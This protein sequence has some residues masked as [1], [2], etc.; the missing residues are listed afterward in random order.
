MS[1]IR[2]SICPEDFSMSRRL[3]NFSMS[4]RLQNFSICLESTR[5]G[6]PKF[7]YVQKTSKF[8][9][10]QKTSKFFYLFGATPP[11]SLCLCLLSLFTISHSDCSAN[12]IAGKVF[13]RR[14][15]SGSRHLLLRRRPVHISAS[16]VVFLLPRIL[17]SRLRSSHL[18]T[19]LEV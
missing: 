7:F 5:G 11:S 14:V 18:L 19:A 8:F 13:K 1:F 9:Y 12:Q 15:E 2:T 6:G 3:Q 17:P 4:R 16:L 10:V